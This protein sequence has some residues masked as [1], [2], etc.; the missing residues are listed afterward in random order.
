MSVSINHFSYTNNTT[1]NK[2]FDNNNSA[3]L[4]QPWVYS[5]LRLHTT[6]SQI[7]EIFS[8]CKSVYVKSRM[9]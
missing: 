5:S 8:H 7:F 2:N 3:Q 4:R 6:L 9:Q 1:G